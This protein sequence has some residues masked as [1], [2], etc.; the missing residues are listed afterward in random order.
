MKNQEAFTY[1]WTDHRNN[2]L[3]IGVHKHKDI[4][5][6]YQ[7]DYICDGC[8]EKDVG[9]KTEN[10]CYFFEEYSKRP[11]DFTRQVIGEGTY[12]DCLKL[13]TSIL[14]TV[15]AKH[16]P[17]YYNQHNGDGKF[18]NKHVSESQKRKQ[19]AT[20]KGRPSPN[21]GKKMPP[22]FGAAISKRM[23]GV[24]RGPDS[25]ETRMKKSASSKGVA[26]SPEHRKALSEANKGKKL[27]PKT[28]AKLKYIW[29]TPE[30]KEKQ[31]QR[32]KLSMINKQPPSEEL[33]LIWSDARKD[34]WKNKSKEERVQITSKSRKL[35]LQ[36][37]IGSIWITN[38]INNKHH[39]PKLPI[40]EGF[41]KGK[42]RKSK[43]V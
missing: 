2:K 31:R 29:N 1:C 15:D 17:N 30:G 3:Y 43:N 22:E 40:P 16:D 37:I 41:R 42:C 8:Y 19:S 11:Q 5:K 35:A 39:N 13:E 33:L 18:Y 32:Q 6:P 12:E 23:K 36:T 20:M 21:K 34:F 9:T 7:D 24:K 27:T 26:K 10:I 25:Q 38:G 28:I 4:N 14:K